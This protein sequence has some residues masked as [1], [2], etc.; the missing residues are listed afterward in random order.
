MSDPLP[1]GDFRRTDSIGVVVGALSDLRKAIIPGIAVLVGLA[2]RDNVPMVAIP[3]L[4]VALFV[5]PPVTAF[6]K[7][8]FRRYRTGP[9]DIRVESGV[10]ARE[11]RSVPYERIQDVSLS[12]TLLSRL[13]GL[14]EV[15][16]ETGAGGKDDLTLAYLTKE[17]GATMT[18]N[19]RQSRKARSKLK[20]PRSSRW[21]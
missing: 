15:R 12:E 20:A 16:F 21:I 19:S 8:W 17:E 14:V 6:A 5:L 4:I 1:T 2:T 3:L 11:A 10:L 7:W 18:L 13:F 9:E